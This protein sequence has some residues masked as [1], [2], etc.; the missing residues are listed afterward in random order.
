MMKNSLPVIVIGVVCTVV[1]CWLGG[2]IAVSVVVGLTALI[3]FAVWRNDVRHSSSIT[4]R[5]NMQ[6]QMANIIA[7]AENSFANA[8]EIMQMLEKCVDDMR[9]AADSPGNVTDADIEIFQYL[10]LLETAVEAS[11]SN[12]VQGNVKKLIS[13]LKKRETIMKLSRI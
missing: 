10:D 4:P 11:N 3:A 13:A 1:A 8:P 6:L 12:D 5:R 9:C 7:V 2:I